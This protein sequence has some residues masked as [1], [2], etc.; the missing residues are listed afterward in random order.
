MNYFPD[1][2]TLQRFIRSIESTPPRPH[3]HALLANTGKV[4]AD[5]SFRYALSVG[6]WYRAGGLLTPNGNH[7]SHDLESW[8]NAELAKCDDDFGQFLERYT[9]TG[10]LVTRH[11]GRTHYFVA[12]YGPAPEDFLQLEVE[13]LQEILDR[14]L[15]DPE[16]PPL[17]RTDLVEPITRAK[18]D[19][20]PTDSPRYRFARLVD[21]R[22]ILAQQIATS[23]GVAPLARFLSD[24]SQSRATEH[25]HFCEHW[26]LTGL[27]RYVRA[28]STAFSPTLMS[29]HARTL[30]PFHWDVTKTG[31]Y[32]S[33]QIRDFDR[34]AGYP[35]AWYFHFVASK[36]VPD[37][38]AFELKRD[39][40]NG[41]QYLAD[42]DLG[43]LQ[44][45]MADPY[46]VGLDS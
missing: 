16:Q 32:L 15:I 28:A 11:M 14:K 2:E 36:L 12:P 1:E 27:D 46:H 23:S 40:D 39:L 31:I 13:E 24:W 33:N 20:H 22:A 6:G 38:L 35:A 29:V 3:H 18:V 41:Y 25:H 21:A 7:L 30:K 19:A 4:L 17:D 42:R 45:L 26:L 5:C 8:V 10:L 34:A 9:D 44:Q 37:T 43:L